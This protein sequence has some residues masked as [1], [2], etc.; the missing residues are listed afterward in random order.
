MGRYVDW[1]IVDFIYFTSRFVCILSRY[2]YII[3]FLKDSQKS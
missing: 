1:S 2:Y 3:F